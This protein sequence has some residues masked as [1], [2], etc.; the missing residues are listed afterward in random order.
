MTPNPAFRLCLLVAGLFLLVAA[1]AVRAAALESG[2]TV[3]V[4]YNQRVPDSKSVADY[5][6]RQREVPASQ[7][8]GFDLPAGET[9]TRAEFTEQ[10]QKP[11]LKALEEGKLFTLAPPDKVRRA[12]SPGEIQSR[13]LESKIRYAVLCYGVPTRVL[14]DTNLVERGA[15]KLQLELR[16]NGA[17]VDSEL[18]CLPMPEPRL[19][20]GPEPNPLLGATNWAV[21]DP[22]NGILLVTRLD[23]PTPDIARKLVD[24]AMEAETN[25][26]WGRA[27]FDARGIT[28][29]GAE[30]FL[31]DNWMRAAA[32]I[33]RRL[34]FE[35]VLDDKPETFSAGFPM[36]H[37]AIYAGW[38]DGGVSGPFTRPTVEFM[39]GAFAYHLHSFSAATIRSATDYWVGPLLAKG[40]TATMGA[41]DEPY[42]AGTPDVALFLSRLV[43][44]GF[45]FG[46]AAWAAQNSLSWQTLAVG[47][48]LY[49]PFARRPDLLHAE[50]EKRQSKLLEWSHLRVINLNLATGAGTNDAI[51]YVEQVPLTRKSAVLTE[52][53]ADLYWSMTKLSDGLD[54][55]E[56]ALKLGP[57]PAQKLRL[58]LTLGKRRAM[59]G[60]EKAAANFY[61]QV[62]KDFPDYPDALNVYQN[63]L[64]LARNLGQKDVVEKCEAEIKRLT[65]PPK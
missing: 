37:I 38:Y 56:R 50:L 62:L 2:S 11:L 59:T 14:P 43:Y 12:Q 54:L 61:Q 23:G 20:A 60:P 46:E 51:G 17:A 33:T 16:R 57:S 65:P 13:V 30:Y 42:L 49:R 6:A 34:G 53:L 29:S 39:P 18:A 22:T 24:K 4:I 47:D 8:L 44:S 64:P 7:V 9:M 52:K 36:S 1:P 31:G 35:T 5:Y 45:S 63:L 41:V 40:A 26:L 3:V 58:L 10:L 32:Q 15:E 21:L 19:L 55:Y 27:Y 48:P 25:G 28:N